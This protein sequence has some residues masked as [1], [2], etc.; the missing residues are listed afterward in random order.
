MLPV[1][2]LAEVVDFL[3]YYDLDGVKFANRLFS[4]VAQQCADVTHVFDFSEFAFAI[5]DTSITVYRLDAN[6]IRRSSVAWT[7]RARS[8]WRISSSKRFATAL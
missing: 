3:G 5:L 2:T 8:A 4:A 1:E 6:R 7:L